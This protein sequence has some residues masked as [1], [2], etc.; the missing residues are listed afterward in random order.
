MS[1]P[2]DIKKRQDELM[3]EITK[4]TFEKLKAKPPTTG[5]SPD[6]AVEV[7]IDGFGDV[8]D[9]RL[10][11]RDVPPHV[12]AKLAGS[13]LAAWRAAAGTRARVEAEGNPFARRPGIAELLGEQL[14]VRYGPPPQDEPSQAASRLTTLPNQ[15]AAP[16]PPAPAKPPMRRPARPTDDDDGFDARSFLR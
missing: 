11:T 6:G 5:H 13:F 2:I 10:N 7:K 16:A 12:A 15:P 1:S 3:V 14:N 9:V 4:R 8:A